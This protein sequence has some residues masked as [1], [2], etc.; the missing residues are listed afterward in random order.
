VLAVLNMVSG[1][2]WGQATFRMLTTMP[3]VQRDRVW[4]SLTRR[5]GRVTLGSDG[6]G[7]RRVAFDDGILFVCLFVFVWLVVLAS[8]LML[9]AWTTAALPPRMLDVCPE[10]DLC[11]EPAADG[12]ESLWVDD[13]RTDELRMTR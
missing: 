3:I 11:A 13:P 10:F 9:L 1:L 5:R 8:M 4:K 6:V 2:V 7:R 12:N